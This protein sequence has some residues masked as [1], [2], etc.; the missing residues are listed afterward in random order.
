MHVVTQENAPAA[1][2]AVRDILLMYQGIAADGA[3]LHNADWPIRFD[4]LTYIDAVQAP[5]AYYL[6]F[7]LLRTGAA[8]V[9]VSRY[10]S[11]WSEERGVDAWTD[12]ERYAEAVT[13]GR[14]RHLP[15]IEA[16]LVEH[17]SGRHAATTDP[18]CDEVAVELC[19]RIVRPYFSRLAEG[20]E[21]GRGPA[22]WITLT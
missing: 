8:L 16:V 3:I 4:P 11:A 7:D 15:D 13:T 1:W 5:D 14:L 18:W 17:L 19:Q 2:D 20:G 22:D 9:L 21:S 10:L 6:D 12:T